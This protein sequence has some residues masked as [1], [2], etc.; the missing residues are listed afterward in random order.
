MEGLH[1]SF[2]YLQKERLQIIELFEGGNEVHYLTLVAEIKRRIADMKDPEFF[3]SHLLQNRIIEF[4]AQI[5]CSVCEQHGYFLPDQLGPLLLCP[6]CRNHFALP[7]S[8]P[9]KINWVYRGIG[10]FAKTNKASGVMSVFATLRLFLQHIYDDKNISTLYGFELR[11]HG[12]AVEH[13]KEVDLCF[14]AAD[15][16]DAFRAPDLIFCECKTY[17]HFKE[18]DMLRMQQLGNAFPGAVLVFATLNDTL[19]STE[20]DLLRPRV[21]HFQTGGGRRPRNPLLI[22]TAQELLNPDVTF[23]LKTYE[24]QMHPS[25]EYSDFLG[26]LCEMTLRKHLQIPT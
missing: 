10:P 11:K 20:I 13:P 14:L 24:D 5:K 16:R 2:F 21:Q 19:V 6:N 8:T 3:I 1:G 18:V 12:R 4:G 15:K 25:Q 23:P 17:I 22:L 26:T 9:K 7:M